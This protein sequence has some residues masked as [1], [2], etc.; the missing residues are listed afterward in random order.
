M[1]T[2]TWWHRTLIYLGLKE[3][4]EEGYDDDP[5]EGVRPVRDP[6]PAEPE[7]DGRGDVTVRSLRPAP[8]GG[9]RAQS[10]RAALVE[11]RG[12]D[13]VESIGAR[14]RMGQAVLFD[15][16][17]SDSATARRV[18]DFVSGMTY[19]SRGTLHK[20]GGRAFLLVPDGVRVAEDERRRLSGLGYRIPAGS[21]A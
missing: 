15:A 5:D 9:G 4:P 21:D 6:V 12:F 13:D 11:I 3:E 16:A 20:V 1:S 10:A 7:P 18:L 2:G 19:V 17:A 8:T 14:F